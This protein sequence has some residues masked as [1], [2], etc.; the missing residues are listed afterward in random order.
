MDW[1]ERKLFVG[2]ESLRWRGITRVTRF[3]FIFVHSESNSVPFYSFRKLAFKK[4]EDSRKFLN[5]N[6]LTIRQEVRKAV[7]SYR[8]K[9]FLPS[10]QL[11]HPL[12]DMHKI[13]KYSYL[14]VFKW[15]I[16]VGNTTMKLLRLRLLNNL[17]SS[18]SMT[19]SLWYH[20]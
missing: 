15:F 9:K 20:C 11:R 13:I 5:H 3:S 14:I 16:F 7:T 17:L 6:I 8:S 19:Y 12:K 4:I 1:K 10:L 18:L 2:I